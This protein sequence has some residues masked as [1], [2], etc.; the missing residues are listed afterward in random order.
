MV[1]N[2]EMKMSDSDES[3]NMSIDSQEVDPKQMKFY[4]FSGVRTVFKLVNVT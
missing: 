2:M 4:M 1:T 3:Q